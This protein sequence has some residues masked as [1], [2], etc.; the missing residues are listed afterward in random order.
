[1][2]EITT[3][4]SVW[5][6]FK[7]LTVEE[8]LADFDFLP[9]A[10]NDLLEGEEA[11]KLFFRTVTAKSNVYGYREA[12][13]DYLNKDMGSV[14]EFGEIPVA[15]PES[16]KEMR[17]SQIKKF[18]LGLRVAWEQKQD[19]DVDAVA[20]ELR[21]RA[22]TIRRQNARE[23][24]AALNA[25]PIQELPVLTAWNDGGNAAD[26]LLDAQE[27]ILGAED[28]KGRPFEYV[29]KRLWINPVGASTMLRNKP[30]QDFYIG[31]LAS[32]NPLFKGLA[33]TPLI[34]ENIEVI[35]DYTV[36]KDT[37]YLGSEVDAGFMAEREPAWASAFL[38][39]DGTDERG[40][41]RQSF[42][43]NF[44]HRRGWGVDHPKSIVKLTG[45]IA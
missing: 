12:S 13:P 35:K 21:A 45:L 36:P 3:I 20:K 34:F 16:G 37:A 10:L 28:D 27:L 1:M 42:R 41:A 30:I 17:Y 31:S 9:E 26:S 15:D 8:M 22:N 18:A 19:N 24:L 4:S 5:D 33:G 43:S 40:G 14:S 39:E 38:P 25:A 6:D 29:P 44:T 2:T 7:E 32:E 23:A 11:F